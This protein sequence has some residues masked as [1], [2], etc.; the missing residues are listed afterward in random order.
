[1]GVEADH[2]VGTRVFDVAINATSA[3][4]SFGSG[5][6]ALKTGGRYC[7]FSGLPQKD[8][9]PASLV[10][11]IHYRQLQVSGGYGCTRHQIRE[12]LQILT[13]NKELAKL[14]IESE[15]SLEDVSSA[16][17][18]ILAGEAMKIV[19]RMQPD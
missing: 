13:E 15:I 2:V 19:M 12:A 3:I 4:E 16:F 18:R 9:V 14:L 1:V 11:E 10:N 6:S 5:I 17:P 8:T 7:L